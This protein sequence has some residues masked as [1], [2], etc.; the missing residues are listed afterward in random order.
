MHELIGVVAK[1]SNL[2]TAHPTKC[3]ITHNLKA[4]CRYP[5]AELTN[6]FA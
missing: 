5:L 1:L 3:A 2:F 4:I 6:G